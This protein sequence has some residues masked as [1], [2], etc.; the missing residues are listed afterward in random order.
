MRL[1]RAGVFAL[2]ILALL[3][4]T[5]WLLLLLPIDTSS[6]S[7]ARIPR[8]SSVGGAVKA[9]HEQ[10]PL[11]TPA[12][13]S[14]AAKVVARLHGTVVQRGW[15]KFESG[16]SQLDVLKAMFGRH[17]RPILR[18]TVPEGRT[19]RDI[20]SLLAKV[21]NVDSA[22]F[23][24]WCERDSVCAAFDVSGTTMEGYLMPDTYTV[25][26]RDD[27]S[28]VGERMAHEF[29]RRWNSQCRPLLASTG[30]SRHAI[31]TLAS[32]VQAEAAQTS[33]MPRIAG[34]Y[35]NRLA[36]GMRLEADPTV[37]YATGKRSR[38]LY[39][40]LD[41]NSPYNTYRVAGLPPGPIANPGLDALQAAL[42]PE[43]HGYL[44]FVARGDGSGLHWFATNGAQHLQNV[45]RYRAQR[46]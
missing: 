16:D 5:M 45:Q 17:R 9:V 1:V 4:G 13:V 7:S 18:V 15:I 41:H 36:I 14:I 2:V 34:V 37:Q 6:T 44:F 25:Y 26:W 24:A 43:R 20:A 11:P 27:A 40:H 35:A 33:E 28:T 23:V 30:R 38:V 22:D 3:A 39:R 12:L 8:G 21:A 31:V 29:Q 42:R 46:K 19:Y 10:C 32:I